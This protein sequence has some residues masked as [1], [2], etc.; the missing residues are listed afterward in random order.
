MRKSASTGSLRLGDLPKGDA[1][2]M[3]R[4]GSNTAMAGPKPATAR[5]VCVGARERMA[6]RVLGPAAQRFV[7]GLPAGSTIKERFLNH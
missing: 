6:V 4:S 3:L 5:K 1:K 7:R 2:K